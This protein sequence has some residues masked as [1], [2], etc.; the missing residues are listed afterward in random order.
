MDIISLKEAK[1]KNLKYYFTGRPCKNGHV[2]KRRTANGTC[3]ECET[4]HANTQKRR[5]PERYQYNEKHKEYQKQRYHTDE[6]FRQ[7]SLDKSKW[8]R[9][10]N[11]VK[12]REHS[13][14]RYHRY[15]GRQHALN[16]KRRATQKQ[17]TPPWFEPQEVREVYV[18]AKRLTETTG[19]LHHVDHIV[20]LQNDL[21][22]GLHCLDNLRILPAV[23]NAT[24]GN[25][26]ES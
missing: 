7:K 17:A 11:V 8:W 12:A 9:N 4:V 24:K 2:S 13:R 3:C 15:P 6:Q 23:E 18:E 22:C 19:T 5:H 21:V 14:L 10:D 26:F 1:Q 25:T 20:P 16:A